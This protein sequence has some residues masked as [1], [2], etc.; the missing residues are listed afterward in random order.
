MSR[1]KIFLVDIVPGKYYLYKRQCTHAPIYELWPC[2]VVCTEERGW[3]RGFVEINSTGSVAK[4]EKLCN[5]EIQIQGLRIKEEKG[6]KYFDDI[7]EIPDGWIETKQKELQSKIDHFKSE[8][9]L[10]KSVG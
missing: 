6:L 9:N 7:I 1:P 3:L 4:M 10:I 2:K 5:G 8:L